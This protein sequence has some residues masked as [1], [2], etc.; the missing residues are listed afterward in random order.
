MLFHTQIPS[1]TKKCKTIHLDAD[2][3]LTIT[4][5]HTPMVEGATI[6]EICK[7]VFSYQKPIKEYKKLK[8]SMIHLIER[9]EFRNLVSKK[10][11]TQTSK[12]ITMAPL[13]LKQ[14]PFTPTFIQK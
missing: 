7:K 4:M 1:L 14:K 9:K 13:I 12:M 6:L 8:E 10:V 3:A 11:I 5:K 2:R